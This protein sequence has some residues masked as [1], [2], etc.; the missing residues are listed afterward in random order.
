MRAGPLMTR[1]LGEARA[2]IYKTRAE[3][4]AKHRKK[5]LESLNGDEAAL[6]EIARAIDWYFNF[7]DHAELAAE[8]PDQ[9][10]EDLRTLHRALADLENLF[11]GGRRT[12]LA[13]FMDE[14]AAVDAIMDFGVLE[15][16]LAVNDH[17]EL[18][19][20]AKNALDGYQVRRGP[21]EVLS[22]RQA[23]RIDLVMK[24]IRAAER[25]GLKYQGEK[26]T[27]LIGLVYSSAG[28]CKADVEADIKSAN[29]RLRIW[30]KSQED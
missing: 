14:L 2:K 21:G 9:V 16:A 29:K 12:A 6:A 18:A 27:D 3:N 24:S 25:R 7:I 11:D 30:K 23:Y 15:A 19:E 4:R 5:L 22:A 28:I 1:P 13:L 26:K 20:A 10:R 8:T 17:R